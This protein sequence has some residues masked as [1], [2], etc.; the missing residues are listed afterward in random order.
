M[1]YHYF[2]SCIIKFGG[3]WGCKIQIQNYLHCSHLHQNVKL[4]FFPCH[5]DA[6]FFL[7]VSY[8][9]WTVNRKLMKSVLKL[10]IQLS[11]VECV[12]NKKF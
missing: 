6:A 4:T 1:Y 2:A 3:S 7:Q 8:R 12:S 11:Y 10:K 5:G 9:K